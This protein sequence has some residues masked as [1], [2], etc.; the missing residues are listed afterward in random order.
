M[1]AKLCR[2][3]SVLCKTLLVVVI[4]VAIYIIYGHQL[5]VATRDV[6]FSALDSHGYVENNPYAEM[7]SDEEYYHLMANKYGD[8][9]EANGYSYIHCKKPFV[10]HWFTGAYVWSQ[11]DY[12]YYLNGKEMICLS[13]VDVQF[14]YKL[15]NGEWHIIV[16]RV[17]PSSTG[18]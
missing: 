6:M 16:C 2:Q 3:H 5:S 17:G 11:Y 7:I 4:F 9:D 12:S 13:D 8:Y 1:S 15:Q 14:T 10:L 18:A